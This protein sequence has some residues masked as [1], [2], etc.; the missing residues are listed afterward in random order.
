MKKILLVLVLIAFSASLATARAQ[1]HPAQPALD[2]LS[3]AGSQPD[4]PGPLARLSPRLKRRDILNAMRKVADWQLQE[5][6]GKYNIDWTYA[7]L[8]DGL[9]AASVATGD[10]RYRDP[11]LEVA[12]QNQ[13]QLGPRLG[14]ADDEAVGFTYLA[15]YAAHHDSAM[16][17]PTRD[18]LD[19]VLAR[20]DDP[21]HLLWWWCDALFM[22]PPVLA[23]LTIATGDQRY[24]HFMD[25]EWDMTTAA[26]YD[27]A[28]HLYSRD[29][30]FLA[31]REPNG[32]KVFWSRG[33]GWVLAG[34]ALVIERLPSHSPLRRKYVALFRDMA[35]RI[36]VLQ[37]ADGL[38]RASLLAPGAY[39]APEISGS[40]LFTF[41]IASGINQHL[42]EP[43][44]FLPVVARSWAG[45][46][47]HVYASGRLGNIQ[48]V[49]AAPGH[50]KPS[51]SYV[52]GVGAFLLAGS[53]LSQMVSR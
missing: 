32:K 19:K 39:P 46:L 13:W 12:R 3:A 34:L 27:P 52:Y 8:Y 41:A 37:P 42:L 22:A 9:L 2:E 40:A 25:H 44:R 38:W 50:F 6:Q 51:S 48:P 20:P 5:S 17:A 31:Q 33:N 7:A 36:A 18:N 15:F 28:E 49:G 30:S 26:L 1:T 23:Q 21:Q 29:K 11:V 45:M 14:H 16:L 43:R 24:L 53:E 10:S 35:A 47:T 4:Q